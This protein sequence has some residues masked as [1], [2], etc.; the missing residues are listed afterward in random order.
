ME[1][2]RQMV[3]TGEAAVF[4]GVTP[5]TMRRWDR[6]GRLVPDGRTP[7]GRRRYDLVRLRDFLA[8]YLHKMHHNTAYLCSSEKEAE[9]IVATRKQHLLDFCQKRGWDC[10]GVTEIKGFDKSGLNRLLSEIINN[11]AQRIVFLEDDAFLSSGREAIRAVC[12]SKN[13]EMVVVPD[14]EEQDSNV[15]QETKVAL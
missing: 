14:H 2:E 5:Q 8:Q 3:S 12:A 13:V 11:E 10:Y 1:T 7:G 15:Y 6:E 4:L 9:E